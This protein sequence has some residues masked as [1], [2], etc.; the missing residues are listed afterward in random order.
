MT[1]QCTRF[2]GLRVKVKVLRINA[3]LVFLG[4]KV[5]YKISQWFLYCMLVNINKSPLLHITAKPFIELDEEGCIS[6]SHQNIV[7]RVSSFNRIA[8][9]QVLL[10]AHDANSL[11]S[12]SGENRFQGVVVSGLLHDIKNN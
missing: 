7:I 6:H 1:C 2:Y 11:M 8:V 9:E 3:I 10:K 5:N 12:S 4:D